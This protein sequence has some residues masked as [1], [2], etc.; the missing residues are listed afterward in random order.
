M[1]KMH[2]DEKEFWFVCLICLIAGIVFLIMAYKT[3][4]LSSVAYHFVCDSSGNCYY[5]RTEGRKNRITR[6]DEFNL[7]ANVTVSC[8]ACRKHASRLIILDE[9]NNIKTEIPSKGRFSIAACENYQK[10][11]Q[12]NLA[13]QDKILNYDEPLNNKVV[14][15][16]LCVLYCLLSGVEFLAGFV[17]WYSKLKSPEKTAISFKG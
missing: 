6:K 9:V 10:M 4:I 8:E 16:F 13:L 14:A 12:K 2:K 1:K 5:S 17:F 7:N 15:Y 3:F 11:L